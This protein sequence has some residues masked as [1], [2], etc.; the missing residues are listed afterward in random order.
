LFTNVYYIFFY[1]LSGAEKK[2]RLTANASDS[3]IDSVIKDWLRFAKERDG[4]DDG[5]NLKKIITFL[6]QKFYINQTLKRHE[7]GIFLF[8]TLIMAHCKFKSENRE[9]KSS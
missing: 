6:L 9:N 3:E 5:W 4:G 2:N 1:F 8:L 7:G